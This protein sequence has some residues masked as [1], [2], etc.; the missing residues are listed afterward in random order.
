[1]NQSEQSN[2]EITEPTEATGAGSEELT[3]AQKKAVYALLPCRPFEEAALSA[4]VS[5]STLQ[6]WRALPAF[7]KAYQD[8]RLD[9]IAGTAT[10]HN[11][12]GHAERFARRDVSRAFSN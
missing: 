11:G 5:R 7:S 3:P 10:S 9:L 2:E 12:P 1:M 8:K 6:R 4:E